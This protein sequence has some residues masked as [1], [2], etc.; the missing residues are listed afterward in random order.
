LAR[1]TPFLGGG[2]YA[3]IPGVGAA[4]PC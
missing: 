4:P 3:K 1:R 2:E